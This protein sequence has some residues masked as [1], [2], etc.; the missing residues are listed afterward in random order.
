MENLDNPKQ[1]AARLGKLADQGT[2]ASRAA[3]SVLLYAWNSSRFPIWDLYKLDAEN[4]HAALTI[5]EASRY[6]S[7]TN[8]GENIEA[9]SGWDMNALAREYPS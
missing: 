4:W 2:G 3:A 8:G 1:A 9:W 5:I 6:P 7:I